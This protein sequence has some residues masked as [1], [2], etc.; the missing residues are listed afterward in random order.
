MKSEMQYARRFY[1]FNY[2]LLT[3]YVLLFFC[4]K[5]QHVSVRRIV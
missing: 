4:L 3:Q 2:Y 1:F 5:K